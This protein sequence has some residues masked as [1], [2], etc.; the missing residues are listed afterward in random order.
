MD[1]RMS[2]EQLDLLAAVCQAHAL[3]VPGAA[4]VVPILSAGG[5]SLQPGETAV[6]TV[7]DAQAELLIGA[8]QVDTTRT[9]DGIR[10][11]ASELQRIYALGG[12]VAPVNAD[13]DLPVQQV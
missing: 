4:D 1:F 10:G 3:D 5:T 8:A 2:K 7:S 11:L 12:Y 6:I 13:P 9:T